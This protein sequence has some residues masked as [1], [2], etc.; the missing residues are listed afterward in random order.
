MTAARLLLAAAALALAGCETMYPT[1]QFEQPTGAEQPAVANT[2]VEM[3]HTGAIYQTSQY[4]PLFEDHRARQPGDTLQ[5]RI[6]EKISATAKSTSSLDKSSDLSGGVTALPGLNAAAALRRAEI[7]GSSEGKFAGKGSTENS[8]DFQGTITVTVRSVL[9]NGHLIVGGEKQIGVNSNV[10]VL[11][12]SGQVDPRAI[13]PGNVV[14]STRIAN[15]RLEQRGRG[16]QAD[17]NAVGWLSRVFFSVLWP[18]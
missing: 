2:A 9:P 7:T 6:V 5:V 8:N 11:R 17:T 16:A 1:V 12:F 4:R 10:D 3:P 15:V 18:L 14:Q 13:E